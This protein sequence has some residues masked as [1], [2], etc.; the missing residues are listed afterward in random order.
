MTARCGRY[1]WLFA[2]LTVSGLTAD[3]ASKATV[4][5]LLPPQHEIVVIPHFFSIFHQ[6]RLNQ[7]AVFGLGGQWGANA[8]QLF[9]LVSAAA[10]IAI[11]WWITR[12]GHL[13]SLSLSSSLGLLL[14]GALG[15]LYDRARLGGVRDFLW[16]YYRTEPHD[17]ASSRFDW[18]IF[19]VADMCLVSGACLLF[20]YGLLGPSP[21]TGAMATKTTG[22]S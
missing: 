11:V 2:V 3:L 9:A 22:T 5:S 20:L 15:N 7:G 6:E 16:L 18:P 14:A 1:W 19:N 21:S 10:A 12:P 4:F 8:N 17:W 13:D